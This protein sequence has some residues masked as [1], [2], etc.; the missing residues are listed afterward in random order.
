MYIY[1]FIYKY[2]EYKLQKIIII[3][4][5]L[6]IIINYIFYYYLHHYFNYI[7]YLFYSFLDVPNKIC[8]NFNKRALNTSV[9]NKIYLKLIKK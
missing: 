6:C 1:S 9:N 8:L 4:S 2:L 3:I 7:N 5:V